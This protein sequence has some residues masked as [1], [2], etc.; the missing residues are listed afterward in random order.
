MLRVRLTAVYQ[1]PFIHLGWTFTQ[2]LAHPVPRA[3]HSVRGG[4]SRRG[5]THGQLLLDHTGC[6]CYGAGRVML[7]HLGKFCQVPLHELQSFRGL[8]KTEKEDKA[9]RLHHPT[10]VCGNMSGLRALRV[11]LGIMLT[12]RDSMPWDPLD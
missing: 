9:G 6:G 8:W 12:C 4:H 5:S 1:L 3:E 10:Y 7:N 2:G 11:T